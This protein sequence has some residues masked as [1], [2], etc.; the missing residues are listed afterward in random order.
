PHLNCL[1]S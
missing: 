1:S